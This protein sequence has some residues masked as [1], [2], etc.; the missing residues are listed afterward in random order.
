[1]S[2]SFDPDQARHFVRPD[3]GPNCL[4]R[5]SSDGNSR[6]RVKTRPAYNLGSL[7]DRISF[8]PFVYIKQLATILFFQHTVIQ[9]LQDGNFFFSKISIFLNDLNLC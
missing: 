6:Q 5:L 1:M 8:S 9:P 3:L 7:S 4:Q 2:N